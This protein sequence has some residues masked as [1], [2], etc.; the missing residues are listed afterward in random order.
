M[1]RKKSN[2]WLHRPKRPRLNLETL[3]TEE[4]ESATYS[5][6]PNTPDNVQCKTVQS[7]SSQLI[8]APLKAR[9]R[10]LHRRTLFRPSEDEEKVDDVINIIPTVLNNLQK[11][12]LRAD[13]CL[14]LRTISTEKNPP[15]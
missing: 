4:K 12:G 9:R 14:F 13:F 15:P 11:A 3:E 2:L 1:K 5:N 8:R 10:T 7:S 6:H